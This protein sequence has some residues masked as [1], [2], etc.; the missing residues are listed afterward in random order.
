[1][2]T[3]ADSHQTT[4]GQ[5]F[6]RAVVIGTSA[7]ALEA[8]SNLLPELPG[9]FPLPVM[10]VV[11]LPADKKSIL[12]ELLQSKCQVVVRE[13]EDKEPIRGG[14]VYVAP[15]D[16]HLL[17]EREGYLSLSSEEPVQYS[18]PSIDVLFESAADVYGAGLIGV[19]LTGANDDGSRG[20]KAIEIAGGTVLV[21]RPD[22]SQSSSM[23]Q[24]AL[25]AC[26]SAIPLS[27]T[28]IA[29]YLREFASS[30]SS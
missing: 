23:P 26:V 21:Q 9:D 3:P 20:S 8:L 7:G 13:A 19:V 18:R 4:A 15:P 24:A 16:Y 6:D 27:L 2:T 17:V 29:K 10:L 5:A 14:T 22:L 30:V 28:D 12:P 11:H 1:M 25:N